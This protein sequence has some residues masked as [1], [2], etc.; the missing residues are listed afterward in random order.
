MV[1]RWGILTTAW[2]LPSVADVASLWVHA[3]AVPCLPCHAILWHVPYVHH[4]PCCMSCVLGHA[5]QCG[6]L[7]GRGPR[8]CLA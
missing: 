8:V 3:Y 2:M 5:S 6:H 7:C 1:H 4:L